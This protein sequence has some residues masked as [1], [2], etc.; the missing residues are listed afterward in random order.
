MADGFSAW[1]WLPA[2]RSLAR[3]EPALVGL[4]SFVLHEHP[5]AAAALF[6]AYLTDAK[7]PDRARDRFV[8]KHPAAEEIVAALEAIRGGARTSGS[9][10][11]PYDLM[12][13]TEIPMSPYDDEQRTYAP[14]LG[15]ADLAIAVEVHRYP[16][17][18][19]QLI[20]EAKAEGEK[21]TPLERRR[22]TIPLDPRLEP[23]RETF[24]PASY[25]G[26]WKT[27][28]QEMEAGLRIMGTLGSSTD[29]GEWHP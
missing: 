23:F 17:L 5:P 27:Q 2:H 25:A 26:V 29:P 10:D 13:A 19:A 12:V 20:V 7:W 6:L 1:S 24:Q 15:R 4:L 28:E 22:R 3:D 18:R 16:L 9:T 11:D 21:L 14:E 8:D